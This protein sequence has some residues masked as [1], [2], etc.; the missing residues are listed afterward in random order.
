MTD[1]ESLWLELPSPD[2]TWMHDNGIAWTAAHRV[3]GLRW[4]SV[5]YRRGG[6]FDL[7]P[8]GEAALIVPAWEDPPSTW[9]IIDCPLLIDLI[10]VDPARPRR[11][12]SYA[13]SAGLLGEAVLHE[14]KFW[15]CPLPVYRDPVGW[16][17]SE[18]RGVVPLDPVRFALAC[19]AS[20]AI[21]L[22]G[23][24]MHHGE[25]LQRMI[26]KARRFGWPSICI[27][28]AAA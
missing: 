15:R 9:R 24:D 22:V 28:K 3:G 19:I 12:A 7:D 1:L 6:R 25:Q 13:G 10:A 8:E 11:F 4:A 2:S 27:A 14:A 23:E 20:P 16:L 18:G 26:D 17:Q 5:Q 21:K